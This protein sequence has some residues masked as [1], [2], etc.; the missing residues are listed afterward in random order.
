MTLRR[1]LLFSGILL[2]LFLGMYSWNQRTHLLD[3]MAARLGLE[4]TGELLTPLDSLLRQ[5]KDLWQRYFDLVNVHEENARL[6]RQVEDLEARLLANAED[7]AEL[8]RLRELIQL[9]PMDAGWRRLGARVLAGRMGPNAVL[10][11]ITI[12]RGYLSGGR[13]GTPLITPLGL[14][15]RVLKAS[16]HSAIA[17]LITDPGS[18]IAV[19]TQEHRASGILVGRGIHRKLEV[20][21]VQRNSTV[22]A[23]EILVTSGLDGKYPKGIPVARV[24]HVAP[25]DYTQFMAITAEPLVNL[26]RLEEVL[27]LDAIGPERPATFDGQPEELVGPPPPPTTTP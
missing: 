22:H 12:N 24:L 19:F 9:P 13:P 21:F 25:S 23:D 8:K 11:S 26:Q 4:V 1:I 20:N 5:G 17:M 18:H 14:V 27:L 2:I 6:H 3:D 15:G 7:L 10:D 16:A